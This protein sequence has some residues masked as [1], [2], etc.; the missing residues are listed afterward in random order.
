MANCFIENLTCRTRV[1]QPWPPNT[2]APRKANVFLMKQP[3]ANRLMIFGSSWGRKFFFQDLGAALRSGPSPKCRR[4]TWS[5]RPANC[6]HLSGGTCISWGWRQLDTSWHINFFK[7]GVLQ[8]QVDWLL[9][10]W[11][12]VNCLRLKGSTTKQVD[13]Q[14]LT[15]LQAP[16]QAL[17]AHPWEVPG[18]LVGCRLRGA[19]G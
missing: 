3:A 14:Q 12:L 4:H 19:A 17:A 11:L 1:Y 8:R 16:K 2:V 10:D 5:I 9:V 18:R 7:G 13:P 15:S 6:S